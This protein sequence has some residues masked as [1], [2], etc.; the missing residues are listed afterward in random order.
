MGNQYATD[1]TYNRLHYAK[2]ITR[3]VAQTKL[4]TKAACNIRHK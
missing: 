4:N 2:F 1:Y 3:T